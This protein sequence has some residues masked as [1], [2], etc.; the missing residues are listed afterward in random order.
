M[1]KN[2]QLQRAKSLAITFLHIPITETKYSP[3]VVA[4]PFFESAFL[5]DG[6]KGTFDAL[7]D[8]EKYNNYI[9]DFAKK[10]IEPCESINELVCLIRKSYR[11]TYLLFMQKEKIVTRKECGNLLAENWTQIENLSHD[12]NVRKST[13]LSWIRAADQSKIEEVIRKVQK[14]LALGDKSRN[15]SE[16]EAIAASMQAQKLLAKYNIEIADVTGEEKKEE[17]EQVIADVGTGNKWKY[18]LA[19][20]IADGYCCKCYYHGSESVVFYGYQSDVLIARRVF[21]YLFKVGNSLATKYVKTSRENGES[22]QGLYNSFCS[23]FCKGV[24]SELQKHCTA[25]MLI[26]PQ[27]V[28]ESFDKFSADFKT[29]N[30]QINVADYDAYCTGEVEGKRALNG[31]YI[32]GEE[33]EN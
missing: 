20:A 8:T 6:N 13:V 18:S 11:L 15:P 24:R 30:H 29:V 9:C 16:A 32:E 19:E 26:T 22:T 12:T 14:L 33:H 7:E 25:L 27:P 21:M 5:Y 3:I 10:V 31:Q 4:H 23:G 17:I 1:E 2:L 28:I